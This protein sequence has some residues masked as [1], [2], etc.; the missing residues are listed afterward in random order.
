MTKILALLVALAIIGTSAMRMSPLKFNLA[1]LQ[2][3]RNTTLKAVPK[4]TSCNQAGAIWQNPKFSSDSNDW[5]P[6]DTPNI[7]MQGTLSQQVNAG[8]IVAKGWFAGISVMDNTDDMCNYEG[9]PF[10][11]PMAAGATTVQVPF[12]LPVPPFSGLLEGKLDLTDV[13]GKQILCI[14]FSVDLVV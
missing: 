14:D 2:V 12:E 6:G 4:F 3:A 7:I 9:T 8:T 11:C 10:H 1:K 5:K 13:S